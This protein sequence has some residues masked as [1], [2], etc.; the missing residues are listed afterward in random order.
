[1][2][3]RT[4]MRELLGT[5]CGFMRPLSTILNLIGHCNCWLE[6]IASQNH[7]GDPVLILPSHG[8]T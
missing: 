4:V 7:T 3:A 1:M 5:L 2:E 8:Q 6:S